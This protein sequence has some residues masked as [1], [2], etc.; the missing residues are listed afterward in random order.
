MEYD[1]GVHVLS[2]SLFNLSIDGLLTQLSV[3]GVGAR[4]A[5]LYLGCLTY[6]DDITLVSPSIAG[7]QRML[8]MCTV[9]TPK[10]II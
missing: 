4:M 7:L 3:S 10:S 8:D 2:P 9:Y 6:A 5:D 1:R